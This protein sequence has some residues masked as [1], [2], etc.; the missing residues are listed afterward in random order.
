MGLSAVASFS[1]LCWENSFWWAIKSKFVVRF[2][3]PSTIQWCSYT[4]ICLSICSVVKLLGDRVMQNKRFV[5]ILTK[6]G[7]R[8]AL[9]DRTPI[10]SF[11]VSCRDTL[12]KT[13]CC[14]S[15]LAAPLLTDV[16]R[17]T[18]GVRYAWGHR[19]KP[20]WDEVHDTFHAWHRRARFV[21]GDPDADHVWRPD[22]EVFHRAWFRHEVGWH[23][24]H[25][26]PQL[27]LR[28]RSRAWATMCRNKLGGVTVV[29]RN[30]V[31][32]QCTSVRSAGGRQW[33]PDAMPFWNRTV[34]LRCCPLNME[35]P[36]ATVC[37]GAIV[38][39]TIVL[40]HRVPTVSSIRPFSLRT[41]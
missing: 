24:A 41:G 31:F 27:L 26:A 29:W 13:Q 5:L 35:C 20:R 32:V 38:G 9:E 3:K 11:F 34:F 30:W 21:R 18:V 37:L 16:R 7:L 28:A 10:I 14:G 6:L 33:V 40:L 2:W 8:I 25:R 15:L 19:D 23:G 39:V 36:P 4:S 22:T 12:G 17:S 1:K